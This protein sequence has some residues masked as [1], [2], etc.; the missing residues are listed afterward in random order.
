VEKTD[1]E[2]V[3]NMTFGEILKYFKESESPETIIPLIDSGELRNALIAWKSVL[4]TYESNKD[5][6]S[7][8]EQEQWE[9]LWDN[10]KFDMQKFGIVSGCKPQ[11]IRNVFD[12]LKGL[13]LIY[14]DGTI[15]VLAT[16]YLQ[17]IIISKIPK[18]K[19]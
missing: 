4:I 9:W 5:C 8:I 2:R 15:N 13:R 12:R 3:K 18:R 17:S 6:N 1:L 7:N 11:N 10:V 19:K 14:P 16:S